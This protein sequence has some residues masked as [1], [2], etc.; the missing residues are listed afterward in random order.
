MSAGYDTTLRIWQLDGDG[1]VTVRNLPSPLNT[2]AVA[3]DGEIVTAGADGKVFFVS[4][5]GEVRGEVE[6]SPTPVID[7]C[8]FART[9][10]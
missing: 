1:A 4:P 8:H 5:K 6:A 2:V 7:L 3:P 10:S 9:A